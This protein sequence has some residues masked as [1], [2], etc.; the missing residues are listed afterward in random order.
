MLLD[1]S[2]THNQGGPNAKSNRSLTTLAGCHWSVR[3]R[4][5][6]TALARLCGGR[7]TGENARICSKPSAVALAGFGVVFLGQ[8]LDLQRHVVGR[9][10]RASS[11]VK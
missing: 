3:R 8:A 2:A 1:A 4:H 11:H 5:F 9:A 7:G 10:E 6:T